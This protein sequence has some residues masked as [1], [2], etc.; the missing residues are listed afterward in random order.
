MNKL[1]EVNY[2]L[3]LVSSS[4]KS[5]PN[6]AKILNHDEEAQSEKIKT[7]SNTYLLEY[8]NEAYL[9]KDIYDYFSSDILMVLRSVGSL[10][11]S[12][13]IICLLVAMPVGLVEFKLAM[14]K[15]FYKKDEGLNHDEIV[16]DIDWSTYFWFMK[17]FCCGGAPERGE[18]DYQDDELEEPTN[19][20]F[21][22]D[23]VLKQIDKFEFETIDYLIDIYRVI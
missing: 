20:P 23:N 1:V 22:K 19:R 16:V 11:T 8:L 18:K 17:I 21:I 5:K 15:E 9:R 14:A 13:H 3:G 6:Q 4:I 10:Y 2:R 12:I 7:S